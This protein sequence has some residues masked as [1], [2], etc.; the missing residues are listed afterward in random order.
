MSLVYAGGAADCDTACVLETGLLIV[1]DEDVLL[2]LDDEEVEQTL[3]ASS[4]LPVVLDDDDEA[5]EVTV[6]LTAEL[7]EE[8]I[9]EVS[10]EVIE[11][12]DE[13][14]DDLIVEEVDV[15]SQLELEPVLVVEA[16]D[17]VEVDDSVV[18][19]LENVFW[20]GNL[21]NCMSFP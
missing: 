16:V 8:V 20:A 14:A 17:S 2:D 18:V 1:G 7:A 5:E 11:D 12:A 19:A 3:S 21:G 10:E 6:E 15:V 4:E 13:V 9:D